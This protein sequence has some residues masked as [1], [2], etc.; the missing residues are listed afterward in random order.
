VV[1]RYHC[2]AGRGGG[3]CP[4]PES[5]EYWSKESTELEAVPIFHVVHSSIP[6]PRPQNPAMCQALY[7]LALDLAAAPIRIKD[8]VCLEP[9]IAVVVRV[10]LEESTRSAMIAVVLDLRRGIRLVSTTSPDWKL[11]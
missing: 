7:T 10:V 9:V 6:L 4:E 1:C 8:D 5:L 2:P 3:P 11:W